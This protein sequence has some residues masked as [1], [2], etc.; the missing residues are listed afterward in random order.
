MSQFKEYFFEKIGRVEPHTGLDK[1][2]VESIVALI[3]KTIKDFNREKKLDDESI[4]KVIIQ[5]IQS[6][7]IDF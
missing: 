5:G 4:K 2:V 1:E 6:G 7:I 3:N